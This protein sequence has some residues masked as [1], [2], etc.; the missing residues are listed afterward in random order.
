[1]TRKPPTPAQ[2]L[3]DLALLMEE[4][5]DPHRHSEPIPDRDK[6]RNRVM[7]RV[8]TTTQPGLLAQLLEAYAEAASSLQEGTGVR[9]VPRS[10]PPGSWEALAAHSAITVAAHRWCWQLRIEP[11]ETV[12]KTLRRLVGAV[13]TDQL[14]ALLADVRR[15][16]HQAA[17]ATGWATPA[18]APTTPC[19]QCG[20]PGSL[21]INLG[22]QVASCTNPAVGEDD[23][24]VCGATW[25]PDT[26]GLL[27]RYIAAQYEQRPRVPVR[28][29]R[30]GPGLRESDLPSV[31]S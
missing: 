10:R 6:H 31:S 13:P 4:L 20:K 25:D 23:E 15:W 28:S 17:V 8:W 22:L 24:P 18:Y 27:A 2:Q 12:E 3:A 21:R 9:G 11:R 1:M 26:I 7:R 5:C 29:G 14:G 19:P 16:R 30:V